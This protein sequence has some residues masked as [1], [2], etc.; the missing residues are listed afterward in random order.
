VDDE[1]LAREKVRSF[2]ARDGRVEVVGE[3]G[4]GVGAVEVIEG[5]KPDLVFLDIQM[6]ELDGFGVLEAL[7]MDRLPRVIFV[8]AYDAHAVRAFEVRALDYLLKPVDRDRFTRA[9]DRALD[10]L[11]REDPP[12]SVRQ[13]LEVVQD[14]P[15]DR[16]RL[17]RFLV[18]KRGR[19]FLLPAEE[20][21]WIG[22]AGNYVEVHTA[23]ESHLV[24]GTLLEVE[25][26]LD[27]TAF[28]RVHRSTVVNLACIRE[29]H[30]WS[31]GDLLLIMNSGAEVKMSRR[32]REAI[33]GTFG[34]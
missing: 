14:L 18:R 6:P 11:D 4:N 16:R 13:Q 33:P 24:R 19:M 3:A 7:E 15:Q 9:L 2:L 12:E 26:R 32:Y 28:A 34:L 8:T 29:I 21:E 30:P 1:P 23:S 31:H 5:E 27:P 25:G 22:A 10:E 17:D 20:V